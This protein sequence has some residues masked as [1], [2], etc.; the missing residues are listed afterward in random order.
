M[1]DFALHPVTRDL[2]LSIRPIEGAERVA[3]AIGI[4]LRTWL[5]EWFL[6]ISH[7]VPYLE[8]VLV[9]NPNLAIV[10][11]VLRAQILDVEGVRSISAFSLQLDP[12]MRVLNVQ[13]EAQSDEGLARG[14]FNINV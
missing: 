3:Q 2:I 5:G 10:E 12:K 8:N 1:I 11:S 9:K 6:D 7:G 13:F 14:R 4:R